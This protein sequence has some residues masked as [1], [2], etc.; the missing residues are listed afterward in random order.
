M[1]HASVV[2]LIRNAG[3]FN[4]APASAAAAAAASAAAAAAEA[5]RTEAVNAAAKVPS[6]SCLLETHFYYLF[7]L[8]QHLQKVYIYI[9]I[10]AYIDIFL[11]GKYCNHLITLSTVCRV[12]R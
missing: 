6:A 1:G 3:S 7:L 5:K 12:A 10:Y 4:L 8:P 11:E 2:T 9:N